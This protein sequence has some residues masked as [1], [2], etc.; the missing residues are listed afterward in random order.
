[1][2]KISKNVTYKYQYIASIYLPIYP[3]LVTSLACINV[4]ALDSLSILINYVLKH[5][6]IDNVLVTI[7]C[8]V[9]VN[10]ISV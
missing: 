4:I 6:N 8:Q 5:I 9:D 1:M 3:L 7:Y 2:Y 10:Q